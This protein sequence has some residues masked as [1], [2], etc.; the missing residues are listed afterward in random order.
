VADLPA[1][2]GDA[3]GTLVG[4]VGT[5]EPELAVR[6]AAAYARRLARPAMR[7]IPPGTGDLAVSREAG[8]VLVTGGT[9]TLGGLVAGHLAGAGRVRGLVLVSRSG[10][11]APGAAAL[12]AGLAARGTW[13]RVAACDVGDRAALAGWMR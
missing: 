4:A 13:V 6:G 12:A 1:T 9:G 10:P 5:G 7:P 3:L 8:T 2:V 11:A